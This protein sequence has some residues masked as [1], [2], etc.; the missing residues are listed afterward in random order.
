MLAL[1]TKQAEQVNLAD[2]LKKFFKKH[3]KEEQKQYE[4]DIEQLDR[5]RQMAASVVEPNDISKQALLRYHEHLQSIIPRFSGYE[6][7]MKLQFG[8]GEAFKPTKRLVTGSWYCDQAAMLFNYGA[9]ETRQGATRDR[10]T[11][12]GIRLSVQHFKQAAGVFDFI[13]AE[14]SPKILGTCP[15]DLTSEGLTFASL[16]ALAQA[17]ACYY[18][19]AVK[20]RKSDVAAGKP[21]SPPSLIAKLAM[22]CSKFYQQAQTQALI[23]S[24]SAQLDRSWAGHLEYQCKCFG[25]AAQYWQSLAV[26][27]QAAQTGRGYGEEIARLNAAQRVLEEA[28]ASARRVNL[29]ESITNTA[30]QLLRQVVRNKEAAE[31]DNRTIYMEVVPEERDLKEISAISTVQ[32]E[33]LPRATEPPANLFANLVP[34]Q[35][36]DLVTRFRDAAYSLLTTTEAEAT[37][38][39]NEGRAL[40]SSV[41]LPG[42]L[43]A[44]KTGGGVPDNLWKKLQ[45]VQDAGG[46]AA[47]R[48]RYE[49]LTSFANRAHQTIA[50]IEASLQREEDTDDEF[51]RQN[52][53]WDGVP[54]RT[55]NRDIK[56][57]VDR[58]RSLWNQARNSDEAI[59][60]QLREDNFEAACAELGKSRQE[61]DLLMPK[62]QGAQQAVD[63]SALE[64]HLMELA[65]LFEQRNNAS[66]QLRALVEDDPTTRFMQ[67][68]ATRRPGEEILQAELRAA[69]ERRAE[70]LASIAS[71]SAVM[72]D[73]MDEHSKFEK[74]R[75]QDSITAA[76]D[77]VVLRLEK[78]STKY[79]NIHS[80]LTAGRTF[81]SDLQMRLTS[82]L[83]ASDDLAYTQQLQRQEFEM[84]IARDYERTEQESKDHYYAMQVAQQMSDA[85]AA[86][87]ALNLEDKAVAMGQ[88]TEAPR[89]LPQ[90]SYIPPQYPSAQTAPAPQPHSSYGSYPAHAPHTS[91]PYAPQHSYAPPAPHVLPVPGASIPHNQQRYQSGGYSGY[92]TAAPA[93]SSYPHAPSSYA[94][95]PSQYPHA[96]SHVAPAPAPTPAPAQYTPSASSYPGHPPTGYASGSMPA[97]A[98]TH[99]PAH[100]SSAAPHAPPQYS[101][102]AAAAP[103][104]TG[105][106]G[107]EGKV[108]HLVQMGFDRQQAIN[109]LN[110]AGGDVERAI[111]AL[112]AA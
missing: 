85:Q 52:P 25:A 14:L 37:N 45:R 51:R 63:T 13:R 29:H 20:K 58:F 3:F 110:A 26:K 17:Q 4:G 112:L 101:Y 99:P 75:Q 88:P 21:A 59:V 12:D 33:P 16:T 40:L 73:I 49:E 76:R 35:V 47:L 11:D 102:N 79:F 9:L 84:H 68:V 108:Q 36:K 22:Q 97:Y 80:Q 24:L 62:A 19:M 48:H 10:A 111:N 92:N 100:H 91:A 77:Q 83:Q 53:R 34:R 15:S 67:A 1:P 93:P 8:W 61:L 70:V 104:P 27:D 98:P 5:L 46:Y 87:G 60:A 103:A 66:A 2:P 42:A 69:E 38:A 56:L 57:N 81:Y 65:R 39:T 96:P 28:L 64:R 72:T 82:L 31:K 43:E 30:Q 95:A 90:G 54:S 50:D 109:A 78:N 6:S 106:S 107:V 105:G 86:L 94:H 71:Q 32:P 41:G 74:A 23:P 44:Y 18:E 55:L 89:G 7:E